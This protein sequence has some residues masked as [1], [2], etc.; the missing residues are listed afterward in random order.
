MPASFTKL[1]D[2]MSKRLRLFTF[3]GGLVVVA[4]WT[5]YRHISNGINFDVVGQIGLAQ[6]WA[7]GMMSGSQI[8]IT[9]Y[10]IK[11]PVYFVA[12]GF[13]M[14]SPMGRLLFLALLFNLVTF[15]LLFVIY[16]KV[17]KLYKIR[18]FDWFYLGFLWLATIAGDVFWVDYANSRNL[19]IV[20]GLFILYLWLRY[21]ITRSWAILPTILLVSVLT[22]F[23]D[24]LMFYVFGIGL[25][26][27]SLVRFAI[28]RSKD[29]AI[30]AA[31]TTGLM[32]ISFLLSRAIFIA[33]EKFYN[34]TFYSAPF[35]NPNISTNYLF[36]TL[37]S[38][39]RNTLDIFGAN[40]LQQPYGVNSIRQ[41]LN[42]VVLV[43][44]I[45]FLIR[46]RGEIRKKMVAGVALTLV[47][48]NYLIYIFSGQVQEWAT[49]RYLILVP[50]LA[51]IVIGITGNGIKKNMA[52]KIKKLWL[53]ILTANI[54]IILGGLVI[55]W[56][57]RHDKDSHIY[58]V[59]DFMESQHYGYAISDRE[60]GISASYISDGTANILPFG[61]S[62]GLI[63]PTNLFYDN[64]A[65]IEF[66]KYVGEVPI[67]LPGGVIK[68]GDNTCTKENII[69][70]FGEPIRQQNVEGVGTTLI[71]SSDT[72]QIKEI[73]KMA[74]YTN[75]NYAAIISNIAKTSTLKQLGNC[76]GRTADIIVAH[77]DDDLLFINPDVQTKLS[78]GWCTRT[79]YLTA[80]DDGRERGYWENREKGIKDAYSN[81]LSSKN[82]W[83]DNIIKI[84]GHEIKSSALEYNPSISLVFLRLP[85]GGVNG[86]GFHHTGFS[87]L[88]NLFINKNLSSTTVDGKSSYNYQALVRVIGAIINK[89]QPSEVLTTISSGELSIGDHSDHIATGQ[90]AKLAA[91]ESESTASIYSYAGYPSSK[92][93]SNLSP[94]QAEIKKTIFSYYAKDDEAICE[95]VHHCSIEATYNNYFSRKYVFEQKKKTSTVSNKTTKTYLEQTIQNNS[96]LS[97]LAKNSYKYQ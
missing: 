52:N 66:K 69:A 12:N 9:N 67:I 48:V 1:I 38:L 58:N 23:A 17:L 79:V 86:K 32:S 49:S 4:L 63:S 22:F 55:H 24:S 7:N 97:N 40:F 91:S 15:G 87:S 34:V 20:G 57:T 65:F 11:M 30:L 93:P 82:K 84:D 3:T 94:E 5:I 39:C 59:I 80:A 45:V 56:P 92:L 64:A 36:N 76:N 70:Q 46:L 78:S 54:I 83:V 95:Q 77:A 42:A 43:G 85:D 25:I 50:V 13:G 33:I 62:N 81:M 28:N 72:L 89:D 73:N 31:T 18:K 21:V 16:E 8:G 14:F 26:F 53:I 75:A 41:F 96:W 44:I 74:G 90:L 35:N 37:K 88:N 71:Y 27:Y 6:Q 68:F 19:E 10:V 29:N 51:V 61:C 2:F 60:T 47:S